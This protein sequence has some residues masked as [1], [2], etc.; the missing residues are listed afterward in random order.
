MTLVLPLACTAQQA[1]L[2]YRVSLLGNVALF[3]WRDEMLDFTFYVRR[4]CMPNDVF[5]AVARGRMPRAT[6]DRLWNEAIAS[7][8]HV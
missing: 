7:V 4:G 8:Y 2:S 6:F 1:H 5:N 3:V